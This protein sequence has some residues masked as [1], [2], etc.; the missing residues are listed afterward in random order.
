MNK[1]RRLH[2]SR[3]AARNS[4]RCALLLIVLGLGNFA[5]QAAAPSRVMF[6]VLGDSD[7]HSFHDTVLLNEPRE[8]GGAF[9]SVTFQWTEIIAR[10][11]PHEVDMGAWEKW[12]TSGR[13]ASLLGKIGLEDRAPRKEDYRYNLAISGAKCENLT[14]GMS[15]QTQRL[16]YLMDKDKAAWVKGI[17]T[18]R[19]GINSIG[20]HPALSRFA[21]KGLVPETQQEVSDCAAYVRESVA[22]I[23][24]KHP[25]TRIVLIGILNNSDFIP[26]IGHWQQPRELRNIAA[27][28]DAYD[29]A[30]KRLAAKDSNIL[31]WDDR[32]WFAKYFGDRDEVGK[33]RYHSTHLIGPTPI[34]Y[35]QGD[36]PMN[37]ILADNHAGTVWNGLWA[38]DL[39]EA[40]NRRFG[41]AFTPIT[42]P[43]IA[44]L[45]DPHGKL[46]I[47]IPKK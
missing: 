5:A 12:G 39:L 11:R 16:V 22:L 14:T 27:V 20:T 15:R 19:I 38:R 29:E 24:A 26:W 37:A 42:E 18:I 35:T 31:F 2:H 36:A 10:L 9:R 41:Y 1:I 3:F 25:T 28:L 47:A 33:P 32:A 40:L 17:V 30:L 45:A 34:T 44:V 43:E 4:F 8:R 21:Q 13:L 23:R 46:G 6:G 7:S